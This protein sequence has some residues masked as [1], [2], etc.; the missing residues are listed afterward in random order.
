MTL[1]GALM[2]PRISFLKTST[3]L[4][5][6]V[7]NYLVSLVLFALCEVVSLSICFFLCINEKFDYCFKSIGKFAISS[8]VLL[9]L[10]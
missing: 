1:F 7:L 5:S 2:V 9:L 10:V 6:F 4:G 8:L 3:F